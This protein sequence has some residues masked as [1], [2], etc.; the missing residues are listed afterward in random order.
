VVA[1]GRSQRTQGDPQLLGAQ[2][3]AAPSL[4]GEH[5]VEA[6]FQGHSSSIKQTNSLKMAAAL[7][8]HGTRKRSPDSKAE[9]SPE[10]RTP[11]K[12][13]CSAAGSYRTTQGFLK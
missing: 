8:Q 6:D 11:A 1:H 10:S 3:H 9:Q 12:R 4:G 2:F 13:T 5:F 7:A